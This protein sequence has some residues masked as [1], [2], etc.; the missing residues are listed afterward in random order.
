[1][2]QKRS[3]YRRFWWCRKGATWPFTLLLLFSLAIGAGCTRSVAD[4]PDNA[5]RLY[6]PG[7][8]E[9]MGATQMRHLKLWYAGEA[10][11]W[12]L[13]DYELDEIEEGFA[14]IVRYHP[15]EHKDSPYPLKQLVPRFT[16]EPVA[17]LRTAISNQNRRDF[18]TAYDAL[19]RSCNACHA[20]TL[21]SFNIV[22]RPTANPYS[23][24]V[25]EPAR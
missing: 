25:F 16:T 22:T 20:A 5:S 21:F 14:D 8:G 2:N 3:W 1:M 23:N 11:N 13:A 17:R 6:V 9:T 4:K 7:L 18:T 15:D 12:A 19:T 24:Q 10:G